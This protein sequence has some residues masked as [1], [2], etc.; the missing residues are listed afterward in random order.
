MLSWQ[1]FAETGQKWFWQMNEENHA[2]IRGMVDEAFD[3]LCKA[4]DFQS[5]EEGIA[6][7]REE[8]RDQATSPGPWLLKRT[9]K[10]YPM[11]EVDSI[12][13]ESLYEVFGQIDTKEKLVSITREMSDDDFPVIHKALHWLLREWLPSR[14]AA[15]DR[16]RKHLP[17][18]HHG[19]G[20]RTMPSDEECRQICN[21]IFEE[22]RKTDSIGEAQRTVARRRKLKLR[23]VQRI[24]AKCKDYATDKNK[25]DSEM[26]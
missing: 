8:F 4:E 10:L 14:R 22:Y 26:S 24:K 25:P 9:R 23:M 19:G 6:L 3:A 7:L 16:A 15:A 2:T 13:P 1:I 5:Y 11:E 12:R 20:K 17:Q 18:Y 21:E